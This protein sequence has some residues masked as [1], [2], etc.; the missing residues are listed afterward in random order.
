MNEN[1]FFVPFFSTAKNTVCTF[2]DNKM[3]STNEKKTVDFF[4]TKLKTIKNY[5][6]VL[7]LKKK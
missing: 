3:N 7:R 6:Y 1:K 5:T 2:I 4:G